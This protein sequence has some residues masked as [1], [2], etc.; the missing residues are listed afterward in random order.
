[1][2]LRFFAFCFDRLIGQ[3]PQATKDR[4]TE[5]FNDLLKELVKAGVEGAVR[6]MRS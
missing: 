5:Q 2:T 4:L 6:G 3:L 1:M